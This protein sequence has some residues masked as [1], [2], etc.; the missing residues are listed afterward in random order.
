MK[1]DCVL[2]FGSSQCLCLA[3]FC[4]FGDSIF[5]SSWL[6]L[7]VLYLIVG[8]Y[9]VQFLSLL[10]TPGR[11]FAC[12]TACHSSHDTSFCASVIG[13]KVYSMCRSGSLRLPGFPEFEAV[14]NDL[15]TNGNEV[16]VPDFQV[17]I[18][19]PNGLAIKQNLVDYW[20]SCDLFQVDISDLLKKHNEKYN[21][22]G[23]KRGA[24]VQ[25]GSLSVI[26]LTL[27]ASFFGLC[28][29]HFTQCLIITP[30]SKKY[31]IVTQIIPE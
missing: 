31:L 11:Q 20:T 28:F 13:E 19:V 5:V 12:S 4:L 1:Q 8:Y 3:V 21:P 17:C 30:P 23:V 2:K 6:G 25:E 15:K 18:P 26:I 14:V 9:I 16:A 10:D 24:E 22:H 29:S 7:F 27:H